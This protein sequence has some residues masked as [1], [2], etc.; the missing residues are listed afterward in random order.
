[1]K[2]T[3]YES[4][5]TPLRDGYRMPGEFEPQE[6]IWMLW[7]HRADTWHNGAKPAQKIWTDVI[8]AISEFEPVTVGVKPADYQAARHKLSHLE[9]VHVVEMESNDAW[10]RDMGPIFLVN[11]EGDLRATHFQF[12]AWGGLYD[13]LYFPWDQDE[14]VGVKVTDLTDVVRYRP[15]NFVL[16]G[17]SFSVDGQGTVLTTEMCLLSPGRNPHYTKDEIEEHLKEYLG[18]TKVIWL[19]D[20]ID[21]EGTNGHVDGVAG[22]VG[23]GEV[24]CIWADDEDNPYYQVA[25]EAYEQLIGE[26]DALGN[27]LKVHKIPVG[28]QPLQMTA[29]DAATLDIVE[30][31]KD[32]G[33]TEPMYPEYLNFL[34]VNGGVI[35]PQYGDPNDEIVLERYRAIFPDRK[36]VGVRTEEILYGGGNIHCITQQQPASRKEH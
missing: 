17:G 26:T 25:H 12:N 4:E 9:N 28:A 6:Q 5:S 3:I 29:E 15:D 8:T 31:T 33:G 1:M 10:M 36:V 23:P 24:V 11:D 32:F 13:G 20:G 21:P 35:V 27:P 22:F 18:C 14:L 30:G 2:K 19:K 34:M 7:P 16:E